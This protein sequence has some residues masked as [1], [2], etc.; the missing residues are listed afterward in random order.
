M[1]RRTDH[2]GTASVFLQEIIFLLDELCFL[3]LHTGGIVHH[4]R[5]QA[6]KHPPQVAFDDFANLRNHGVVVFFGNQAFAGAVALVD[7]IVEADLILAFFDTNFRQRR[8]T[9][10]HLINLTEQVQQNMRCSHRGIRTKVLRAVVHFSSC[11]EN[12]RKSLL[13][14]ANPRVGLVVLKH[15]VVARLVLLDHRV[16]KQQCFRLR[17][18]DAVFKVGDFAY[19]DARLAD[20]LLIKITADAAFQVF[21]LA[22]I[23]KG[24]VF[25]EIAIHARLVG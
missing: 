8:A 2:G 21:G 23:D 5:F 13:L 22:D 7:V 19:Q 3:K 9:G 4:G 12:T 6:S 20:L 24:T 16:L 10:T 25:V 14:D 18:D 1:N 17:I 15:D 11:Q